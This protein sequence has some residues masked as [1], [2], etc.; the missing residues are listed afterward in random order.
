[1]KPHGYTKLCSEHYWQENGKKTVKK[2]MGITILDKERTSKRQ[3]NSRVVDDSG[4]TLVGD[5]GLSYMKSK[6]NTYS[7]RLKDYY[8]A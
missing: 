7:Q 2:P 1:M 4:N 6:G 3:L 8:K 5:Q